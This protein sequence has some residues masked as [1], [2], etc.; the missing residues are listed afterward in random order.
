MHCSKYYRFEE[1]SIIL[2][3]SCLLHVFINTDWCLLHAQQKKLSLQNVLE[4]G[5]DFAVGSIQLSFHAIVFVHPIHAMLFSIQMLL[6][7]S[8]I[9]L[10]VWTWVIFILSL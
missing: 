8:K 10:R 3:L 6:H 7:F 9:A 2:T 5:P 4:Q 1:P